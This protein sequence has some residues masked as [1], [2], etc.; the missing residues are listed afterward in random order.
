V[1]T[2]SGPNLILG[3]KSRNGQKVLDE[4]KPQEQPE[5][6]IHPTS[7]PFSF[8]GG[9][10][11]V[12]KSTRRYSEE[13]HEQIV[14]VCINSGVVLCNSCLRTTFKQLF[15]VQPHAELQSLKQFCESAPL[16][17]RTSHNIAWWALRRRD[18]C[19]PQGRA[20]R[21]SENKQS[22]RHSQDTLN[23]LFRVLDK[24]LD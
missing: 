1:R 16:R 15:V 24:R 3:L 18:E 5:E 17:G 9:K 12:L 13:I 10:C 20:L 2:A 19:T 7:G 23:R 6:N 22:V 11:K 14:S 4:S 8:G 21:Q